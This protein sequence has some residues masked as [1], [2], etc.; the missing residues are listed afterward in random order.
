MTAS[1]V[2][3]IAVGRSRRRCR[4]RR[5]SDGASEVVAPPFVRVTYYIVG[6]IYFPYPDGSFRIRISVGMI[7]DDQF[8]IGASNLLLGGLPGYTQNLVIIL[9]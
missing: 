5:P 8:S 3:R 7:S 4:F 1:P 9:H 6:D 2:G